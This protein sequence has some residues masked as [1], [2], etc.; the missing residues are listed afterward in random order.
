MCDMKKSNDLQYIHIQHN[1]V[2]KY[3]GLLK[4]VTLVNLRGLK[5]ILLQFLLV[6]SKK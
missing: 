5:Q 4:T 1:F 2:L 6:Y 3:V